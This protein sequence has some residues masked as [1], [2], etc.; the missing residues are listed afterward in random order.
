MATKCVKF[1]LHHMHHLFNYKE[2]EALM[3]SWQSL[4]AVDT[5]PPGQLLK[6]GELPKW[7]MN[8]WSNYTLDSLF[9]CS[10]AG[11]QIRNT[12][13]R[14]ENLKLSFNE[15]GT[16]LKSDPKEKG[17]Q[18]QGPAVECD[19]SARRSSPVFHHW[20]LPNFPALDGWA[21]W[22]QVRLTWHCRLTLLE[23]AN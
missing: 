23:G 22:R 19:G 7:I 21:G 5:F 18:C 2:E 10:V 11:N 6:L 14:L 15:A 1:R 3:N 9:I 12:L 4:L 13:V 16:L 20:L 8:T 17:V